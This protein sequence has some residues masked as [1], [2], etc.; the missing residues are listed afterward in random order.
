MFLNTDIFY[1]GQLI[2][3]LD[4]SPQKGCTHYLYSISITKIK[5]KIKGRKFDRVLGK[6]CQKIDILHMIKQPQD[7]NNNNN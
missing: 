6:S 3:F 4:L 1:D 2:C 7:N 5:I